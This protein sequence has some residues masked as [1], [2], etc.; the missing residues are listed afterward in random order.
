MMP[1]KKHTATVVDVTCLHRPICLH[2]LCRSYLTI[3]SIRWKN[4]KQ[5]FSW[6]FSFMWT[7]FQRRYYFFSRFH[8]DLAGVETNI[9]IMWVDP[10]LATPTQV[11]QPEL[12][13]VFFSHNMFL[14]KMMGLGRIQKDVNTAV[15]KARVIFP[16]HCWH[17]LLSK[18]WKISPQK[19]NGFTLFWRHIRCCPPQ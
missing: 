7:F 9:V 1:A 18:D 14:V 11:I 16:K 6:L 19:D 2:C 17:I 10:T 13:H 8:V 5:N 15:G 12:Q 4:K 3:W